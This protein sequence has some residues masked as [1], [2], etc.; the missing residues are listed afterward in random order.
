MI[1]CLTVIAFGWTCNA[2]EV[3][4]V[5]KLADGSFVVAID[6]KEFRAIT[7]DKALELAKQKAAL[8]TCKADQ[9]LASEQIAG[10]NNSIALLKKDVT[11]ADQQRDIERG[12]FVRAM[13][14]YDGERK[15]REQSG[16]FIPHGKVGGFG[17][18]VL[19]FLDSGVGQALFKLVIPT[20]QAIKVFT[21]K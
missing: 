4:I 6:G 13:A 21:A 18:K 3:R 20:A 17:G 1:L 10:L 11:I 9:V 5:E 8:E 15:L 19:D 2:Q 14:M 12:N 16:Q 7:G